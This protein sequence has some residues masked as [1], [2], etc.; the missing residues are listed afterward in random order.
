MQRYRAEMWRERWMRTVERADALKQQCTDTNNLLREAEVDH[1]GAW[2]SADLLLTLHEHSPAAFG[3]E[4]ILHY[5]EEVDVSGVPPKVEMDNSGVATAENRVAELQEELNWCTRLVKRC[6]ERECA[7]R[8]RALGMKKRA[9]EWRALWC[10]VE[11]WREELH[12]EYML[13]LDAVAD[14]VVNVEL[15]TLPE[16]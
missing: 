3:P 16:L 14:N 12:E 8:A 11:S 7:W 9:E 5:G 15:L 6:N 1:E 2:D 13:R 10:K 4:V